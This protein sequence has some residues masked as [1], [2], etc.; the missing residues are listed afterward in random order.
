MLAG[1]NMGKYPELDEM[2]SPWQNFLKGM[3]LG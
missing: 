1:L 3:G 2:F